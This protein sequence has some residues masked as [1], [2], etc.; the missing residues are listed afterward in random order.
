[1][2]QLDML[3]VRRQFFRGGVR[4]LRVVPSGDDLLNGNRILSSADLCHGQLSEYGFFPG[5]LRL[6]KF[7]DFINVHDNVL[8]QQFFRSGGEEEVHPHQEI[9]IRHKV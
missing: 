7:V 4:R 2:K 6:I 5:I 8:V 1:M 3:G 9:L